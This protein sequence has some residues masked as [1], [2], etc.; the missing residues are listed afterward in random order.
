MVIWSYWC[1]KTG[2]VT[3]VPDLLDV[4]IDVFGIF[5]WEI[6]NNIITKINAIQR[7]TSDLKFI[8]GPL[9]ERELERCKGFFEHWC[10]YAQTQIN[11]YERKTE[12]FRLMYGQMTSQKHHSHTVEHKQ[13]VFYIINHTTKCIFQ[14]MRF[15][16]RIMIHVMAVRNHQK[17]YYPRKVCVEQ[18]K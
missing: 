17:S 3:K 6:G 12:Q 4:P 18:Q 10:N 7:A 5:S 11:L 15:V 2:N 8:F 16:C 1:L 13:F 14:S 9:K